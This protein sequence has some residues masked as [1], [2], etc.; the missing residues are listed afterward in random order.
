M[1]YHG[2]MIM[3]QVFQCICPDLVETQILDNYLYFSLVFVLF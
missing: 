1:N 3:T 2:N